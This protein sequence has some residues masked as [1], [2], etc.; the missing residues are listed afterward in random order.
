[1][2]ILNTLTVL[3]L[4]VLSFALIVA[5]P[6]LYASSED[7]GRSNRLILLGGLA[8]VALVLLVLE[9]SLSFDNAVVN[10]RVLERLTPAQQL[11]FRLAAA[12]D[13][14]LVVDGRLVVV[15]GIGPIGLLAEERADSFADGSN[16]G[17]FSLHGL[18]GQGIALLQQVPARLHFSRHHR[19]CQPAAGQ[20]EGQDVA[21][22]RIG[23]LPAPV[24]AIAVILLKLRHQC[25]IL[26]LR[27]SQGPSAALAIDLQ[28]AAVSP[29]PEC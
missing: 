2:Q 26:W 6:V 28:P 23:W 15:V 24:A 1:M 18:L 4:V 13:Q 29:G 22:K 25:I 19:S 17:D 11:F 12:L 27:A 7:S 9:I 16:Q 8:W 21:H 5:V 14:G 10:A 3:A 20:R